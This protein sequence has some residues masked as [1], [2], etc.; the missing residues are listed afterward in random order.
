MSDP[1]GMVPHML[2]RKLLSSDYMCGG[3]SLLQVM[4]RSTDLRYQ[5][6]CGGGKMIFLL[7]SSR[8]YN[9][10]MDMRQIMEKMTNFMMYVQM[11]VP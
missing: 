8:W 3:G 6:C 1:C 11:G 4:A 7:S 9:N 10:Q 5:G 2:L